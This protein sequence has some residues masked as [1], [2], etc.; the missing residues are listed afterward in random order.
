MEKELRHFEK[1]INVPE[2]EGD[3]NLSRISEVYLEISGGKEKRTI[4]LDNIRI[5]SY[6][7]DFTMPD[8]STIEQI[9]NNRHAGWEPYAEGKDFRTKLMLHG[10]TCMEVQELVPLAKSWTNPANMSIE[11]KA[12]DFK[13]YDPAQM[14]YVIDKKIP[15]APSLVLSIEASEES[16]LVNSAL[17][18]R[19][20]GDHEMELS[21]NNVKMKKDRDYRVGY[22]ETLEGTDMILWINMNSTDKTSI[23]LL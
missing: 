19:N 8:G 4:R 2:I 22:L 6:L 20:W 11:G 15:H 14:A 7:L 12:F 1:M 23:V 16:P 13:G 9:N 21:I 18:I 10:M 17:I 5:G 3:A